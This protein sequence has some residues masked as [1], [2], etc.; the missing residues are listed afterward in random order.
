MKADSWSVWKLIRAVS[1]V[2]MMTVAT[3]MLAWAQLYTGSI[4]G[5]VEDPSGAVVPNAKITLIDVDKGFTR[6]AVADATGHY[7]F[8]SLPPTNYKIS[9]AATGFTTTVL[10]QIALNINENAS[11]NVTLKLGVSSE[12]VEVRAGAEALQTQDA[13]VGQVVSSTMINQLP[14][15]GRQVYDLAFLAPG[16]SQAPG[17]AFGPGGVQGNNFVSQGSRNAQADVLLDGISTTTNEQ[18][19]G[20][21]QVMYAPSADTVQEFKIQQTNF[22]AEFGFSGAT[23]MNVVTRSGGNQFHGSAYEYFRNT[24]LNSNT[25]FREQ[26]QK[27]TAPYHWNNF[28]GTLGGP[29]KK[30]KAFF[31]FAYDG[32][33]TVTPAESFLGLPTDVERG[34][35][36][37]PDG[38]TDFG[39]FGQVC[40]AAGGSFDAAG[41]CSAAAGQLYNGLAAGRPFIPYNNL[42]TAGLVNPVAQAIVQGYIPRANVAGAGL[43]HNFFGTAGNSG[44]NDQFDAKVDANL[45]SKDNISAR[46]SHLWGDSLAANLLAG[47][48]KIPNNPFDAN[49]QGPVHNLTYQGSLN[50]VHTFSPSTILT[51]TL[52]LTHG[53]THTQNYPFDETSIGLPAN[54]A[55]GN[56]NS[57]AG[58]SVTAAPAIQIDNYAGENGN[59]NFG[60]QPWTPCCTRRISGTCP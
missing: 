49:T 54:I 48:S 53:W 2:L 24:F 47:P 38:R 13:T 27:D 12:T 36:A 9:V 5:V 42:G 22:G 11:V 30:D 50:W 35:A 16:V 41:R 46:F 21:T 4:T 40:T 44:S 23:I 60:G 39:N 6:E 10:P 28:G 18:N 25:Y 43:D 15:I 57:R 51:A 20:I 7:L 58:V 52:G 19:T 1:V 3:G 14:L 26:Q 45:S 32:S 33:R 37:G 8:R 55:T 31:F 29:I 59:A 17:T 56:K 34:L